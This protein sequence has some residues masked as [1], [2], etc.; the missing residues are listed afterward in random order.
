MAY[1][2]SESVVPRASVESA[3]ATVLVGVIGAHIVEE[4]EYEMAERFFRD[5]DKVSEA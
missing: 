1:T 4:T 5:E 2:E 3:E